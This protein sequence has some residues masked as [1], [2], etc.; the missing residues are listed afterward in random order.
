MHACQSLYSDRFV[1]S[2]MIDI[3]LGK[4]HSSL[5]QKL[6]EG[7]KR[8]LFFGPVGRPKVFVNQVSIFTISI[9]EHVLESTRRII[10]VSFYIEVNIASVRFWKPVQSESFIDTV[11]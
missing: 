9:T 3:E 4:L 1:W 8:N 6:H 11:N 7:S 5:R 10:G 2:K